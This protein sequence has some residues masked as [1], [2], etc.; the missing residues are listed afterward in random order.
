MAANLKDITGKRFGRLVAIER[1]G[2]TKNGE[3]LWKCRCDCGRE[4]QVSL[5]ALGKTLSCGCLH[6]E[7]TSKRFRIHGGKGTPEYAILLGMIQRC[8]NPK[9]PNFAYYGA[10]G[11][12]VC[13]RWLGPGGYVNFITDVGLRPSGAHSIDRYPDNDGNYEPGNVR[14]ATKVEQRQNQRPR[15]KRPTGS[16]S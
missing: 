3:S 11:I 15:Q 14:W 13:E 7:A 8:T 16:R 12:T 2:K 1:A 6:A 5:C 4:T 10:R 9:Q